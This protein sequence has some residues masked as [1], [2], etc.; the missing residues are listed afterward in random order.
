MPNKVDMGVISETYIYVSLGIPTGGFTTH[1][2]LG[3]ID[4]AK[5]RCHKHALPWFDNT[6]ALVR[7]IVPFQACDSIANIDEWLSHSGY[8][9]CDD[10]TKFQYLLSHQEHMPE[11]NNILRKYG[12]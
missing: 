4:G 9:G 8:S 3:D 11:I 6:Y 5:K 10:V 2:L 1:V 7:S 12:K